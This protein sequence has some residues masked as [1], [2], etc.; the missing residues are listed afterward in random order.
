MT[1][2]PIS[3]SIH[4]RLEAAA[5]QRHAVTLS[6][7]APDGEVEVIGE[8]IEDV[9]AREGA[10]YLRLSSGLEL[11]LDRLRSLNGI[12]VGHVPG[13]RPTSLP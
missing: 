3:C 13:G 4:D 7:A 5:T 11:R 9:F 10:E 12:P 6:Y 2:I 8:V 1:Y